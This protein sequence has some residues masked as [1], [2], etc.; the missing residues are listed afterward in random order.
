M[1]PSHK[2][3]HFTLESNCGLNSGWGELPTTQPKQKNIC[4]TQTPLDLSHFYQTDG[5]ASLLL[6]WKHPR[7]C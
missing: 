7:P 5:A 2:Q 4:V 3:Q 6:H 1:D